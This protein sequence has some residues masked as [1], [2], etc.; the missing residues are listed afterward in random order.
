M[1]LPH[2]LV[3]FA[4][5]LI[6]GAA[7]AGG[8]IRIVDQEIQRIGGKNRDDALLVAKATLRNHSG[9]DLFAWEAD[10]AWVLAARELLCV[11]EVAW[12]GP[13]RRGER[14]EV[15]FR[16]EDALDCT[17][18]SL[19]DSPMGRRL[20]EFDPDFVAISII[21]SSADLADPPGSCPR[22]TT[23][24]GSACGTHQIWKP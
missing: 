9:R 18:G 23:R 10:L 12:T 8:A 21:D 20:A 6:A 11:T 4:M 16:L 1:L 13:M 17:Q 19:P 14:V 24:S 22:P 7:S 15:E 5:V 3:F 2:L